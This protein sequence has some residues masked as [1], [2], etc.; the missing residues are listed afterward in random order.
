M[1]GVCAY[2]RSKRHHLCSILGF[3]VPV[4]QLY[5]A[6]DNLLCIFARSSNRAIKENAIGANGAR[7]QIRAH[8]SAA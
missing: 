5:V 8:P 4:Q 3:V 7:G 6:R 2:M 1:A